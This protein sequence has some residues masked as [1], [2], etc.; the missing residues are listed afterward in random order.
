MTIVSTPEQLGVWLDCREGNPTD[1]F[2]DVLGI[3]V[4]LGY[5]LD[6]E[7]FAEIKDSIKD[8][9]IS[10]GELA[11]LELMANEAVDWLN[12]QV[13]DYGYYFDLTEDGMFILRHEDYEELD[14][15]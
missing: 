1:L 15:E 8:E 5:D 14:N 11:E 10:Y 6:L 2:I 3:A 7:M 13:G 9:S 4:N 12:D